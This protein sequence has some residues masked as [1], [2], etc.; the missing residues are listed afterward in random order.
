MNKVKRFIYRMCR[1]YYII[2]FTVKY[3]RIER[4]KYSLAI[5]NPLRRIVLFDW[6]RGTLGGMEISVCNIEFFIDI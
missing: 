2:E 1:K 6:N 3:P 5:I 4:D